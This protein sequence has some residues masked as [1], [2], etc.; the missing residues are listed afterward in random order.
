MVALVVTVWALLFTT[1]EIASAVDSFS[2]A[3]VPY[4][5]M[6]AGARALGMGGAFVGV[7]DDATA[8][9][10]NP[11]GLAWTSGWELTGMYTAGMNV[12]RRHNYVGLSHNGSMMAYALQWINAGMKDIPQT[13]DFGNA[14]SLF[15][16]GDNAF[17]LS[18]AKGFDMF[19]LGIT[20]KYLR[21]SVG[22][23]VANDAVSGYGIDLGLGM[24]MTD[25][26]RF[27]LSVQD[28]AGS[29]GSVATVNKIPAT[30]RAGIAIMPVS[31][32]TTAFDMEKTRDDSEYR[33]HAGAEFAIPVTEELGTAI[34]VGLN[35]SKFAGGIGLR[36]NILTFDYAYVVE[37]EKFLQE[38]H[39]LSVSLNFG[40][41]AP[42]YHEEVVEEVVTPPAPPPPP[43]T[44]ACC[45]PAG[46]CMIT[47]QA[48]CGGVNTW[49]D[50]W[51]CSPN[52]CPQAAPAP[53]CIPT[54]AYINFKFGTAEISGADPIPVLEEVARIMRERPSIKVQITGH[55][56]YVGSDAA[57]MTLSMKR[58][59]A[60]KAYLVG[61]GVE[62][63]R[64]FTLGKGESQ[65]IDTNETDIGRARNRR[66]EFSILE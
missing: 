66:I 38:N 2:N 51:T 22:A 44:G 60:V 36:Y 14:G 9:Y 47:T 34:R 17:S 65:P 26:A 20:G 13:D 11:A 63:N 30:L 21:Q 23:N 54:L 61:K 52:P 7:A 48:D 3:N 42:V 19:A 59:E 50:N 10:W 12:D 41:E 6:G 31:G 16:F 58:S 24:A 18:L 35:D 45:A 5:R 28:I 55:T 64:L 57:N 1:A 33:F 56:D 4:L 32:L 43:A 15:N 37:P 46:V 29:I 62:P 39:R 49:H 25:W 53:P 27:G 8:A 40:K